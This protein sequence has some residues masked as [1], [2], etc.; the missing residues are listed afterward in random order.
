MP[1]SLV[2]L[3]SERCSWFGAGKSVAEISRESAIH[4]VS[5]WGPGRRSGISGRSGIIE[6][7]EEAAEVA[8]TAG[9][10]RLPPSE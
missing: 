2:L 7:V 8:A 1:A 10:D 3:R 5:R 9:E 6:F 4:E